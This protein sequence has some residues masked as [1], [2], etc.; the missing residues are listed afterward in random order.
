MKFVVVVLITV[1]FL[2]CGVETDSSVGDSTTTSGSGTDDGNSTDDNTTDSTDDTSEDLGDPTAD[3]INSDFDTRDA[4][5]DQSACIINDTYKNGI[6]DS[7]FDPEETLDSENGISIS[8]FLAYSTDDKK[9]RVTVYYPDIG[10][11]LTD[12]QIVITES[13]YRVGFDQSWPTAANKTIYVQTPKGID[14]NYYGCIRYTLSLVKSSIVAQRVY[15][16]R[17]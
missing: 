1:F 15:R 4:I 7:S 5:K 16:I 11:T 12:N 2:G 14:S 6:D 17:E 10:T 8:S 9:T 13:Y 3:Q